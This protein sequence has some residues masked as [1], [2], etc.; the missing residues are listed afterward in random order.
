MGQRGE[1]LLVRADELF[2]KLGRS[3]E[4]LE[5]LLDNLVIFS[6]ALKKE[7]GTLGKML[8]DPELY[9]NLTD[10]SRNINRLTLEL[11]PI[12]YDARFLADKISR[13]P[14]GQIGL[15]SV[16]QQN[17]QAKPVRRY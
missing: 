10:V 4:N 2:T 9:N 14:S 16:F 11:R 6:N 12:L 13:D 15:R 3:S 7:D 1:R 17:S 5:I 8:N